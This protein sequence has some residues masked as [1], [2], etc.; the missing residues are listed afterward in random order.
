MDNK[1]VLWKD[2]PTP[3]KNYFIFRWIMGALVT[4]LTVITAFYTG[5]YKPFGGLA[6]GSLLYEFYIFYLYWNTRH[7]KMNVFEGIC[8]SVK[9]NVLNIPS[10]NPFKKN[11]LISIY[12]KSQIT[13]VINDDKYVV[14]ISQRFDVEEGNSVQVYSLN[15]DIYELGENA[16]IINSPIVVWRSKI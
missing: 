9:K 16:Y 14:P 6:I 4:V 7:F 10:P 2:I 8:E 12:G 3:L 1:F 13:I 15:T 11:P 5:L